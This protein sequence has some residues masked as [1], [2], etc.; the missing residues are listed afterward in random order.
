MMLFFSRLVAAVLL[1]VAS[2]VMLGDHKTPVLLNWTLSATFAILAALI[3][4]AAIT[5]T[6]QE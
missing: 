1:C 2:W 3:I 5:E 4:R 6:N